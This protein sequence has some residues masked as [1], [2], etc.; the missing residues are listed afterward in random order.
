MDCARHERGLEKVSQRPEKDTGRRVRWSTIDSTKPLSIANFNNEAD[1]TI[2]ALVI[3]G[4]GPSPGK[5]LNLNDEMWRSA[6]Q[7]VVI[8]PMQLIR[9]SVPNMTRFIDTFYWRFWT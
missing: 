7:I 6:C 5:I 4:G 3:S 2:D 9:G 1:C 8:V